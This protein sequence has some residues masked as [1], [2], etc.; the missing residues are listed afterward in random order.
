M[1]LRTALI[2]FG[3]FFGCVL[4]VLIAWLVD[5]ELFLFFP[6]RGF[7]AANRPPTHPLIIL[8]LL[9]VCI[10]LFLFSQTY[11]LSFFTILFCCLLLGSFVGYGAFHWKPSAMQI[12]LTIAMMAG[13]AYGWSIQKYYL[14]D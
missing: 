6:G 3:L 14:D 10:A 9:G 4:I 13:G 12:M 2:L 8:A 7:R 11:A 5:S 1:P